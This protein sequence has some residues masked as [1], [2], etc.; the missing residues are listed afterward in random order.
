MSGKQE[1]TIRILALGDSLTAGYYD[2]GRAYHPYALH[3]AELFFSVKIP[4][5][6][7]ERGI[8]GDQV[9]PSMLQRLNN[10][11]KEGLAYQWIVILGGT[12]DLNGGSSA[13]KI[14]REGLVPMYEM[15]LNYSQSQVKLVVM[16][17]LENSYDLP[18]HDDDH[19]RQRLNEMIRDYASES[20]MKNRIYLVDL[21]RSIPYHANPDENNRRQ[22]WDDS[23]HLTPLGYD[24]IATLLFHFMIRTMNEQ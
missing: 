17:V 3:L 2:D 18:G 20:A 7:D 24:R 15:C 1:Q 13:E 12:N 4:T 16:T 6:I 9:V 19:E 14:F 8:S 21:D 22:I 5:M 11:L 23:T 10:L